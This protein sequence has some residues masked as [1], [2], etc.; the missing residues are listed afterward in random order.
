MILLSVFKS[1]DMVKRPKNK[2][3]KGRVIRPTGAPEFEAL[4]VRAFSRT[5]YGDHCIVSFLPS[6]CP[7]P[8]LPITIIPMDNGR[9]RD[10]LYLERSDR[11]HLRRGSDGTVDSEGGDGERKEKREASLSLD[12]SKEISL[13][14]NDP[15][16]RIGDQGEER[17]CGSFVPFRFRQGFVF[18]S[19]CVGQGRRWRGSAGRL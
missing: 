11:D 14:A 17:F 16:V 13:E 15:V 10:H 5:L 7:L 12:H 9:D 6:F 8:P 1:Q 19:F 3:G 18:V 4:L 2:S